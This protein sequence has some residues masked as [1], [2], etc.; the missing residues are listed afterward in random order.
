MPLTTPQT[1][2]PLQSA[3]V[4]LQ[5]PTGSRSCSTS[6]PPPMLRTLETVVKL[7]D[8]L[9]RSP[10]TLSSPPPVLHSP[11]PVVERDDAPS[12]ST[13]AHPR[14][15]LSTTPPPRVPE[16]AIEPDDDP[17]LLS[18]IEHFTFTGWARKQH[19]EPPFAATIH[20][21]S[22]NS[23]APPSIDLLDVS[24]RLG[25]RSSPT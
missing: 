8:V 24:H 20:C 25:A 7:D 2:R 5:A 10:S 9:P 23:P 18:C 14:P 16:P 6:S 15:P 12:R 21:L 4:L 13:R 1:G 22:L 3:Q 19:P 11:K 17:Y